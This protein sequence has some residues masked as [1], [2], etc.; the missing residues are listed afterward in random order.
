[1]AAR[2]PGAARRDAGVD[3]TPTSKLIRQILG[4]VSE[5]DKAMVVAKLKGARDRKRALTGKVEGRK[6][7]AELRP[8]LVALVRQLRRRRPKGGQRSLR[9]ISA[10]LAQRGIMNERGKPFSAA[11]INSM[12][13]S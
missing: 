4:A 11:S 12:L 10:E 9:D 8:E 1:M 5:F 7:H 3:D 2:G 13:A 6:S